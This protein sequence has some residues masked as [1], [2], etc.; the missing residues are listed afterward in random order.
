MLAPINFFDFLFSSKSGLQKHIEDQCSD[1]IEVPASGVEKNCTIDLEQ[2]KLP[3][4]GPKSSKQKQIIR[5]TNSTR[6]TLASSSKQV[7]YSDLRTELNARQICRKES[8]RHDPARPPKRTEDVDGR[9]ERKHGKG[10]PNAASILDKV[11]RQLVAKA[12]HVEGDVLRSRKS[13]GESDRPPEA[14]D[15]GLLDHTDTQLHL[16]AGH[17]RHTTYHGQVDRTEESDDESVADDIQTSVR[18]GNVVVESSDNVRMERR[19]VRRPSTPEIDEEPKAPEYGDMGFHRPDSEDTV[20]WQSSSLSFGSRGSGSKR[21]SLESPVRDR[22]LLTKKARVDGVRSRGSILQAYRRRSGASL[23]SAIVI[24]DDTDVDEETAVRPNGPISTLHVPERGRKRASLGLEADVNLHK[25]PRLQQEDPRRIVS[26]NAAFAGPS[27][28]R[29]P[30]GPVHHPV[31][32]P[33][34]VPIPGEA[35]RQRALE[36]LRRNEER[37]KRQE[38][39]PDSQQ[40]PGRI[41]NSF[42]TKV[43]NQSPLCKPERPNNHIMISGYTRLYFRC[44]EDCC[45]AVHLRPRSSYS[46]SSRTISGTSCSVGAAKQRGS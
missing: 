36:R 45:S 18:Q 43:T 29:P 30:K 34:A 27:S 2:A 32:V 31:A 15:M 25:R 41:P 26:H 9:H 40:L 42:Q 21:P 20:N 33:L 38:E 16:N 44:Q 8:V 12:S 28:K 22:G 46:A 19:Q 1:H 10:V 7:S 35:S 14:Q 3:M 17:E 13:Q 24:Q 6:P 37:M 39:A 23:A 11:V 4:R 5:S